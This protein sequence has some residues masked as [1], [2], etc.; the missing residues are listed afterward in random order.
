MSKYN[1]AL[2]VT[3]DGDFA[4]L[5]KYLKDQGKLKSVLS[6]AKEGTSFLLRKATVKE[7]AVQYM[8]NLKHVIGYTE[9]D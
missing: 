3:S 4:V 9:I 6:P 7:I 8:D 2:L 1:K 5:V